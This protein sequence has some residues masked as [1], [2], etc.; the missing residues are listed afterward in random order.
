MRQSSCV[1]S[2]LDCM[3]DSETVTMESWLGACGAGGDAG[4][5]L[6]IAATRSNSVTEYRRFED[7]SINCKLKPVEGQIM[8]REHARPVSSL[9]RVGSDRGLRS[10][11]K[12]KTTVRV[13]Q[14]QELRYARKAA[15]MAVCMMCRVQ[16]LKKER[17]EGSQEKQP[18]RP[19]ASISSPF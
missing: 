1:C 7:I 8:S 17:K 12:T 13:S 2:E 3:S 16:R 15:T 10:K 4:S 14:H 9:E 5:E 19:R 11:T 6:S 18:T